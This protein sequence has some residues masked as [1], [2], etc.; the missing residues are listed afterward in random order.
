[1]DLNFYSDL[2]DGTGQ[3]DGDPGFLDPQ[4]FSGFDT[5][6]KVTD[7]SEPGFKLSVSE[8]AESRTATLILDFKVRLCACQSCRTSGSVWTGM[9]RVCM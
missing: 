7:G 4:S 9:T 2:T 6:N 5:D 1:M 8:G 3:H